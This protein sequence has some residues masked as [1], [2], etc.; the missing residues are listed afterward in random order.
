MLWTDLWVLR[1]DPLKSIVILPFLVMG[2]LELSEARLDLSD[3]VD[4]LSLGEAAI[5]ISKANR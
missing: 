5:S 2:S 1:T 4:R 3:L